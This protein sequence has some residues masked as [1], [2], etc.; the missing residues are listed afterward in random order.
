MPHTGMMVPWITLLGLILDEAIPKEWFVCIFCYNVPKYNFS[1]VDVHLLLTIAKDNWMC[2][3]SRVHFRK[4]FAV[5]IFVCWKSCHLLL[6]LLLRSTAVHI[7]YWL[8]HFWII[9]SV[10]SQILNVKQGDDDYSDT[11]YLLR[12]ASPYMKIR[13]FLHSLL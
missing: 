12:Q 11:S 2:F 7:V 8:V 5:Y 10:V 6:A 4:S 13:Y 3:S 9:I 1:E